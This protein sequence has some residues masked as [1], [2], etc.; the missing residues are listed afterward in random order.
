MR[1]FL[2]EELV[3]LHAE[4]LR[5]DFVGQPA[6]GHPAAEGRRRGGLLAGRLSV[7]VIA[8]AEVASRV[9]RRS[10]RRPARPGAT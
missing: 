4:R 7:P 8:L 2:S 10:G 5:N 6:H 3:R 1:P 9:V